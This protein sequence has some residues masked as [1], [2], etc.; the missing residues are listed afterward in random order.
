MRMR[1]N[2][3][4]DMS[5]ATT[6]LNQLGGNKFR[7]MTGAKNFM[8][9]G[10]ALSMRIGRNS[11]N[12]NYLKITLNDSDLYDVRFSKVTKMGE[13]KSVREF[14]DVYNDMLVEIFESLTGMYTSL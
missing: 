4:I 13:E 2:L 5:V 11:S 1:N 14:N 8:D 3:E 6:I 7:V 9:H 12:S 10:N